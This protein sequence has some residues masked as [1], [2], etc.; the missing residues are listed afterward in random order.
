M[1]G[2]FVRLKLTLM[3]NT[4]RRSGWQTVGFVI[5]AVHALGLVALAL[6]GAVVGGWHAP[7]LTAEIITLAGALV[8]LGWWFVPIFLFGVDATLDPQR[9]ATYAI[10]RRSLLAG[11][12]AASLVTIPGASTVL[13]VLAA[14]LAWLRSPAVLAVALAGAPLAVGLCVVGSRA[15]TTALSGVM[16]S[17]RSREV[18]TL[19]GLVLVLALSPVLNLVAN[20]LDGLELTAEQVRLALA[21][22]GAIV[23]WTPLGAPW[24]MA[25]AALA[26]QWL[27]ALGR[28]AV[29]ALA[30]VALWWWWGWA[31]TRSFERPSS[32]G[33]RRERIKGLGLFERFP[34]TPIGA[35]AA[36]VA[37]YWLRDPRYSGSLL[38][39]PALPVILIIA[40]KSGGDQA[41]LS[42]MM[43]VLA[44][45]TAWIL[46]FLPHNDIAYDHTAFALH[47]AT[48]V[49]GRADRWGRLWP[50]F[51]FGVP[52]TVLFAG[53][54]VVITGRP[55]WL[56]PLLGLSLGT[57]A[58]AAGVS[59]AL[60]ARWLYPVPKPGESPF[61]QPQGA[62]SASLVAQGANMGLST[63]VNLPTFGLAMAA[64]LVPGRLGL[65]LGWVTLVVGP[66]IGVLVLV[67]GVRWG[68]KTMER[69]GPELLQ[70]VMSYGA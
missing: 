57:L 67:L 54:S 4:F 37:T 35:V 69:R 42:V 23:G 17:R 11:L 24:G 44:P 14:T 66:V 18:F 27:V 25:E 48:G 36:R 16:E 41:D 63:A 34:A 55:G 29:A 49:P 59:A 62:M 6:V 39:I 22:V 2:S 15:A 30:L 19:V 46:G 8:V 43:L 53:L 21:D 38:V 51:G 32:S 56:P 12:S 45:F 68:A 65:A 13:L 10:P 58:A 20:R 60:S 52:V 28:L 7:A 40:A 5:G 26:G 31:L 3:A 61:K 9:F 64:F 70:Q 33:P 50:L 1:V 47:V